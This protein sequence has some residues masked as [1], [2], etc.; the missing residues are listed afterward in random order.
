MRWNSRPSLFHPFVQK[1]K[2]PVDWQ[3]KDGWHAGCS[4]EYSNG[5]IFHDDFVLCDGNHGSSKRFFAREKDAREAAN[6]LAVGHK[7]QG[8]RG[9]IVYLPTEA[10][11]L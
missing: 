9:V 7:Q 10:E 6:E 5:D 2:D 3:G 4:L 11:A 1:V 8:G